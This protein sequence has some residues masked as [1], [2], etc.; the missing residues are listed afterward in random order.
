[1]ENA[2]LVIHAAKGTSSAAPYQMPQSWKS[3]ESWKWGRMLLSCCFFFVIVIITM[4]LTP[5]QRTV[6]VQCAFVVFFSNFVTIFNHNWWHL[7][8]GGSSDVSQLT[9][10][11]IC[12]NCITVCLCTASCMNVRN[13]WTAACTGVEKKRN[14]YTSLLKCLAF[15]C[16]TMTPGHSIKK[17]DCI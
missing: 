12:G 8:Q 3:T 4:W 13:D 14:V 15:Q 16:N 17:F 11:S 5:K 7:S 6:I 1:M 10:G 2:F 9:C